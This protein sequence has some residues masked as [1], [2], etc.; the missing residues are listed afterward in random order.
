MKLLRTASLLA[1]LAV[2][3]TGLH[4]QTTYYVDDDY[5]SSTTGWGTTHF[6]AIGNAISAAA[7]GD[8]IDVAAGTYT[9]GLLLGSK[10]ITLRGPNYQTA[11][12]GSRV[13]EAVLAA[14][15]RIDGSNT[16]VVEGFD[17]DGSNANP[18]QNGCS[19]CMRG[20]LLG[21]TSATSNVTI[22]NNIIQQWTTGISLAGGGSAGW[23]NNVV[24]DGN[25]LISA[26][27][28]STENAT[29]LT[30]TN[31]T[32]VSAGVG[33][34]DGSS[35]AAF[36]GNTFGGSTSGR[37]LS[38]GPLVTFDMT[39][40]LQNNTFDKAVTSSAISPTWY[41]RAVFASIGSAITGSS[42]GATLSVAAG[43]YAEGLTIGKSITILGPNA[44]N[45]P[46]TGTRVT[47][48]V[49]KPQGTGVTTQAILGNA[50]GIT[51]TIKGITVDMSDC[52][53]GDRF[54]NQTG[55]IGTAWLFE[56]NIFKNASYSGSG[57]WLY[58]GSSTG[59]QVSLLDN[60]FT[61]NA[62]SNGLAIWDT[63]PT[64]IN[65]MGNVWKDNG[66]TAL[67]LNNVHGDITNNAFRDTRTIDVND[68]DYY[69][70]DY[71]SGILLAN[72]NND[73]VIS[74]NR[75][76]NV[77]NGVIV[78]QNV[79]G[80]IEINGNVF[81]GIIVSG[82]RAS[83]S[84]PDNTTDLNGV[85]ITGNTFDNIRTGALAV[86]VTRTDQQ[87]L[88]ASGNYWGGEQPGNLVTSGRVIYSPWLNAVPGT[89][90]MTWGTNSSISA[91][92]TA[93]S[94]GD[95]IN[96]AAGTY[97]ELVNLS[98][99]VELRGAQYGVVAAGRSGA[100]SIIKYTGGAREATVRFTANNVVLDGFTIDDDNSVNGRAIAPTA[101]SGG[102]IRN[103]IITN[104]T[105]AV[106]GDFYGRPT[107]L[108]IMGNLINTEYGIAGTEDMTNL[109]ITDNTF[110]GG[111]S[112]K[113]EAIGIGA[114]ATFSA[115][116]GNT[117]RNYT[118]GVMNY[119]TTLV[120]ASNNFWGDNAGPAVSPTLPAGGRS[121][122][123]DNVTYT[124]WV[125]Q[126]TVQPSP[127]PTPI[128]IPVGDPEV[129]TVVLNFTTVPPGGG[130]V[131]VTTYDTPPAGITPPAPGETAS[132]FIELTTTMENRSFNLWVT[133]TTTTGPGG[134]L[135]AASDTATKRLA[136]FNET[137]GRW[138]LV[139][140]GFY[141]PA[142]FP[143]D[144]TSANTAE[145]T[146]N[147]NHFT[148]FAFLG[149][150]AADYFNTST[151]AY[152][153]Y[154]AK[155]P[156]TALQLQDAANRTVYPNNTWAGAYA[157]NT[158][159]WSLS[160]A[161]P[162]NVFVVPG[163][164]AQFG[165]AD[166]TIEWTTGVLA[167][168]VTASYT[169]EGTYVGMFSPA[170]SYSS[171]SQTSNLGAT[172]KLSFSASRLDNGNFGPLSGQTAITANSF[173]A[174][175]GFT[176]NRPGSTT[177]D[178]ISADFRRFEAPTFKYAYV[179]PLSVAV[180]AYLGDVANSADQT[181]GD[182]KI[183]IND[184]GI[185]S[186]A[187]WSGVTG[188]SG[189]LTNY[190]RK[191]DVGPTIDKTPFTL[192]V[193]DTKIDFEDLVIFA[194]SYGLSASNSLP[195]QAVET[196][197][198]SLTLGDAVV[199]GNE[200][201][202]P[203]RMTGASNELRALSLRFADMGGRF[204]GVANGALLDGRTNPVPVFSLV[205]G[206]N[207]TVDLAVLGLDEAAITGSGDLVWLR[208]EGT[209]SV[210]LA[211]ADA[212]TGG[213]ASVRIALADAVPTGITLDRNYPNPFNPSTTIRFSLDEATTIDLAVYTMLGQ[214]VATLVNGE[215]L[216][217]SQQVTWNG[218]DDAGNALPSGMYIYRLS[219]RGTSQQHTMML[220]K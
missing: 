79:D 80:T 76:E 108:T 91:A 204:I 129:P 4:A 78:Y 30:V 97:N 202:I 86:S 137:A 15:V 33:F 51:V 186:A 9:G 212:R 176:L 195:K 105:R 29:N 58:N 50:A 154:L 113:T 127:T 139:S 165:A 120:N 181:S 36:T 70:G 191:F 59:L 218:T 196:G 145:F 88:A 135:S 52:D 147:V 10:S 32:F 184:L 107:S 37:Y 83:S 153:V 102:I 22:K 72:P 200:T 62:A 143:G 210:R 168:A 220:A 207:L 171:N 71:Q 141:K 109:T 170:R 167:Q 134:F 121:G 197:S 93:A 201:R 101:T 194:I 45:S 132:K 18:A 172:N 68:D 23:V 160:Q 57:N 117:F 47:E 158:D 3:T 146:F 115:F 140:G 92:I 104:A 44:A 34:A 6:A 126:T 53:D 25:K 118:H 183:D 61:D 130:T 133:V 114:G 12:N 84:Q 100:E 136:Y 169:D 13:S 179:E 42:A 95:I 131:N 198:V 205:N 189:G 142:S 214:R 89:T 106:Q 24:I 124:P 148:V 180:K 46:N 8:I 74:G 20:F 26:S 211:S 98:K 16:I 63:N 27:I 38:V 75:F 28:G 73:L 177:V 67:N 122:V 54:M 199:V 31:N 48:A 157:P 216:A 40:A 77:H 215:A 41:D 128:V 152:P 209:P 55:K 163:A 35:V 85:T 49:L 119:T 166:F 159:D 213:N 185:W 64:T 175:L 164:D 21:N 56:H 190:K 206:S 155:A 192:P 5:N 144:F 174:K 111:A 69:F 7:S 103:N 188:F 138:V 203:V 60:L 19:W 43:T 208:F 173:M 96:V 82:V 110:D 156:G 116:A 123:S 17:V 187:Y 219:A 39:A 1:L 125:G 149:G 65:I 81:D 94:A 182:G 14:Y 151:T 90:P 11:G 87:V 217:G 178:F 150:A 99:A 193:I 66:Y 162:F 112:Y 161:Q 2:L